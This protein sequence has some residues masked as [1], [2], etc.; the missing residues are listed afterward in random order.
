MQHRVK[1]DPVEEELI[2]NEKTDTPMMESIAES[3]K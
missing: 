1:L 3:T 2:E